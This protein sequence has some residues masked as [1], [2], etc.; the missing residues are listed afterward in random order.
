MAGLNT[1]TTSWSTGLFGCFHDVGGCCLTLLCP[2]VTFGRI[3]E[4]VDKGAISCCTTGTL[5]TLLGLATGIG[6][7]FY[8]CCYRR[9]LRAEYGLREEPCPDCC[10]HLFC[11]FCALCQE[12]REL[13]AR[14]FHMAIGWDANM[15]KKTGK[16]GATTVAPRMDPGMAR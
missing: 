11:G 13:K 6:G 16:G 9:R 2:C 15:E 4:I 3:A 10:V 12:Y 14:G 7:P 8:A 1:T 5:Y